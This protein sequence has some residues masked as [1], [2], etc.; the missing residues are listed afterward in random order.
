MKGMFEPLGACSDG[1][2]IRFRAGDPSLWRFLYRDVAAKCGTVQVRLEGID[3]P[4][5]HYASGGRLYRQAA[6]ASRAAAR[7][8]LAFLGFAKVHRRGDETVVACG[9]RACQGFLLARGA[10]RYGRCVAL[11]FP[12]AIDRP[13]GS[14]LAVDEALGRRSGNYHLLALGLAYP[15]FY[16][17]L[18]PTLR[19]LF[20]RA[21]VAARTAGIGIWPRDASARGVSVREPPGSALLLPRL[22]RVLVDWH[23][24]TGSDAPGCAADAARFASARAERVHI[25]SRGLTTTFDRV[26]RTDGDLI[27]L[28]AFPEDLVFAGRL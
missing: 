26:L 19:A 13:D 6:A 7:E 16:A 23:M 18:P 15:A 10:D 2:S 21:V 5:T 12:G 25:L 17:T 20:S 1:D 4:E 28:D 24:R 22:F 8:L 27:A 3:A 14:A 9:P 11:A